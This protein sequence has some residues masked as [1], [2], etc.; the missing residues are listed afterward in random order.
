M[1]EHSG[2]QTT[3]GNDHD[4]IWS[5]MKKPTS[6]YYSNYDVTLQISNSLFYILRTIVNIKSIIIQGNDRIVN[7]DTRRMSKP[8]CIPS[9]YICIRSYHIAYCGGV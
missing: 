7:E 4:P 1:D 5:H 8:E 6:G 3:N 2:A 9:N